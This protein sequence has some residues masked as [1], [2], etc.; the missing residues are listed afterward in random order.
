M[1]P[2]NDTIAAIATAPGRG[3]VGVIRISGPAVLEIAEQL[4][5][6]PPPPRRAV[7]RDFVDVRGAVLDNGLAIYFAAPASFTGEE[8]LELHGHGSP[9]ALDLVL[10]RVL[11]LG[12]RMAEPGEF[13]RRAFLNEKLDLTQA[14]AIADLIA[15]DSVEAARA[16]LRSMQGEFGKQLH[17][18]TEAITE[19]R[20]H[21]EAAIDF[22]D[23]EI[24]LLEDRVLQSRLAKAQVI[25]HAIGSV[26]RQGALLR[27]GMH[28]VIAGKPNAGKSS[29]LN[30]LAGYDAA[31]VTPIPGTTRDVLRE[32]I[33]IDGMPLHI[34]DT[35]GLR[36]SAD[37]VEAE[38]I[39]RAHAE[40][41]RANRIIYV[42]DITMTSD[43]EVRN[44]IAKLPSDVPTTVVF[45]KIDLD[46][47]QP[48]FEP[49]LKQIYLSASTGAGLELLRQHL[50][51]CMGYHGAEASTFSARRRHLDAL[52]RVTRHLQQAERHLLERSAGELA[53]EE[54]RLA[55][56]AIGE[57]TG[58]VTSDEL[59]GRIFATF[60]IGK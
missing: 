57:I 46:N 1:P 39:R 33:H 28:I 51:E 14:E 47:I 31:I 15:S 27:S 2:I 11:E 54:L 21:V 44:E 17:A 55:Q 38:G 6:G 30:A 35:A 49:D 41:G 3:G 18:L 32:R 37:V 7:V 43:E 36:D 50:K 12:A 20:M 10:A 13:S 5:G 40:I 56:L 42:V 16:A 4:I 52:Q 26:A 22:P 58:E 23:E 19:T 48:R 8:V 45:N 25:A 29:L 53:A 60:C 34:V 59:L 9:V 24:D